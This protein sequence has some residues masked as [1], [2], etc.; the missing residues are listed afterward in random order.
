MKIDSGLVVKVDGVEHSLSLVLTP[1]AQAP[2]PTPD[3]E[4]LPQPAPAPDHAPIPTPEPAPLPTPDP[5]PVPEPAPAPTSSYPTGGITG[6][7]VYPNQLSPKPNLYDSYIDP[8]YG[9]TIRRVT[10]VVKQFNRDVATVMYNTV[11]AWNRDESK[12]IIYT[13]SKE[14]S[15]KGAGHFLLDGKAYQVL[16]P[17]HHTASDVEHFYWHPT[18]PDLIIYPYHYDKDGAGKLDPT[19]YQWNVKTDVVTELA[20]WPDLPNISFGHPKYMARDGSKVGMF[21]MNGLVTFWYDLITG[22]QGKRVPAANPANSLQ[23]AP[24]GTH[25]MVGPNVVKLDDMSIVRQMHSKYNEH[26][27]LARG[28][29]GRDK[30][31]S[32]QFDVSPYGSLIVEDLLDGTVTTV[33]G[34]DNGWQYP[35]M[36]TH[37]CGIGLDHPEWVGV[38]SVGFS[39]VP[40]TYQMLMLGNISTGEVRRI[41]NHHSKRDDMVGW[42]G[43]FAE[44]H[45]TLSPSGTRALFA[46]DWCGGT[47]DAA[48]TVDLYVV[49]L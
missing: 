13:T 33:I 32:A 31:I 9:T 18:D 21:S 1:V 26:L 29:D 34:Q 49:E 23:V 28:A 27:T 5:T 14:G 10:D 35:G 46:S 47:T 42:P 12:L 8:V 40:L 41:G 38:S 45:I 6:L 25:G 43:Y 2:A 3:P 39:S 19:L 15:G 24:N 30:I 17:I 22:E 44:P 20:H 37:P 48:T 16:G 4:P 36:S 7:T 11:P